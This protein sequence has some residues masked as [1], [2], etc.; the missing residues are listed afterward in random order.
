MAD[1]D[2]E[3]SVCLVC[4]NL[5]RLGTLR[6]R[7][8]DGDVHLRCH[9]ERLQSS[10]ASIRKGLVLVVDDD[11]LVRQLI[12]DTV[13]REHYAIHTA[14]NGQEALQLVGEHDYDLILCNLD[15]LGMDGAR[16]FYTGLQ[17]QHPSIVTRVAFMT[18]NGQLTESAAFG[19]RILKKPPTS[20]EFRATLSRIIGPT[21]SPS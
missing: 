2:D 8:P 15:M 16:V 10:S 21:R 19:A 14:S 12:D 7:G 1:P 18:E 20:H 13:H 6:Y 9:Q 5:I 11:P 4:G 17:Y 3:P